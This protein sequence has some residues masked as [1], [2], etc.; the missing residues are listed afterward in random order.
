MPARR[1][2]SPN[3]VRAWASYARAPI[4]AKNE[5][6][7]N[8]NASTRAKLPMSDMGRLKGIFSETP[9]R[10]NL[11]YPNG[12]DRGMQGPKPVSIFSPQKILPLGLISH[13]A[14]STRFN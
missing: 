11:K 13:F 12:T 10:G 14:K 7:L 8:A 9:V 3:S 1:A 4:P 6:A 5:Y 2:V